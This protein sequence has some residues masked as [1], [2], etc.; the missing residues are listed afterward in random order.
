MSKS[1]TVKLSETSWAV[2]RPGK[3]ITLVSI[4]KDATALGTPMLKEQT[5]QI[6]ESAEYDSYNLSYFGP[7]KSITKKN[8]I[9]QHK[10]S[11][12]TKRMPFV[13]F[14]WRNI[15]FDAAEAAASNSETMM[16]I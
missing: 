12:K 1:L 4:A 8:V 11:K 3:S 14:H 15:N 16:Y 9:V 7:I 13:N 10:Y 2:V 6:G 5:F